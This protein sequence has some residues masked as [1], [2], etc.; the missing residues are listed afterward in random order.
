MITQRKLREMAMHQLGLQALAEREPP[1]KVNV[2]DIAREFSLERYRYILTQIHAV[3]EN[4]YRFL[5]IYQAL[6]TTTV[7]A[8][9][10]IFV[11]YKKWGISPSTAHAGVL[12]LLWLE[13]IIAL[14]TVLLIFIGILAWLDYR[15]EECELTDEAVHAGFRKPPKVGNFFRWYETY[16]IVF[17]MASTVFMWAYALTFVLPYMK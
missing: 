9:L 2:K 7:G 8:A 16:I 3:N 1:E 13:T 6:A 11:W 4:V 12:G 15:R 10:A 17:I 5:A 14:F